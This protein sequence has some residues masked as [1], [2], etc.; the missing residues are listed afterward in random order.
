MFP[1]VSPTAVRKWGDDVQGSSGRHRAVRSSSRGRR[2]RASS[3]KRFAG[4]WGRAPALDADR[5][6]G[7]RRRA[8]AA[9]STSSRARSISRW[10]SSPT[11]S[12]SSS[13]TPISCCTTR[14]A[15]TSATSRST[16]A[17]AVRRRSRAARRELRD[18]QGADREARLPGPRGRRRRAAAAD[19]V[20]LSRADDPLSL[21]SGRARRSCSPQAE[22]DGTFDPNRVY[23][24]Y[25]PSTPRPYLPQ[26]ERVA[27]F[28]QAS[29]EQVGMHTELVLLAVSRAPRRDRGAASTT[30]ACSAGSAT[31]AIRTTSST[32]CSTRT[33]RTPR[34]ARRTSRSIAIPR[35]TS[36]LLDA[37]AAA[38]E[39]R[40]RRST[41]RSRTRS[42]PT[43]RGCRSRTRELV[44]AGR[45]ELEDVVL[46]PTGHPVYPLIQ[47]RRRPR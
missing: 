7:R 26:P 4:Y 6:P 22:A 32:C 25:A 3:C 29:L 44:V 34:R 9:R 47:R 37:Q 46:S 30:C 21:R 14:R 31:P 2:A 42:P 41:R 28:L 16:R 8:A 18:Q 5:V 12:R 33:T 1:M 23:K 17:A 20:G 43:R 35:S 27:R 38:D 40:A 10:R 45:A 13:C 11:S 24:L 39:R 15:T 36:M 19:A